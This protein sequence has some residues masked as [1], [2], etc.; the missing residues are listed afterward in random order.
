[1]K[2]A[3]P[4]EP[5]EPEEPPPPPP[6]L[7]PEIERAVTRS[8]NELTIDLQRKLAKQPGNLLV[9][10]MSVATALAM[11][12]AGSKGKTE[13][14]LGEVLS[15]AG[16][17]AALH[18]GFAG[19]AARWGRPDGNIDL[20]RASRLFGE[21][22]LV[23]LP[24]YLELTRTTFAAPFGPLDLANDPA[25]ARDRINT[26]ARERTRDRIPE[27]APEG[28]IHGGTRL[29]L[30]DVADFKGAWL[31]PFDP[32]AT[33]PM[34]FSDGE[35]KREVPMMRAVLRLRVAFGKAG[36]LRVLELPYKG[37]DHSLV[38]VLPGKR[39]G[40]A[41]IEKFYDFEKLQ[42]WLDAARPIAIDLRLPR[43]TLDSSVDLAPVVARLG[44][45][46]LFDRKRADLG[47]MTADALALSSVHH[48]ARITVDERGQE[49]DAIVVSVGDAPA[50]PQPY[51]VDRPFLFYVRDVRSGA[52]LFFG[53]VTD[54]S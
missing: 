40:L 29:V 25:G 20:V 43:F 35:H 4:P 42:G 1:V 36:K 3:S 21:Q 23:W 28:S 15:I 13:K 31:T 26:W 50:N 17:A 11:V 41:E 8:I 49:A 19:F 51:F 7:T 5:V 34:M 10:G 18:A 54:P 16:P 30:A 2:V 52:L 39:D 27:V 12:H 9:S 32:A 37:G 14:E 53:R 38:I 48:R 22:K 33:T 46:K 24:E 47:G 45:S 6:R 44:A